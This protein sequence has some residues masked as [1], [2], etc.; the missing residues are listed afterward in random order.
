[1][2]LYLFLGAPGQ[3]MAFIGAGQNM[4]FF[5]FWGSAGQN[6]AFFVLVKTWPF[7][8]LVKTWP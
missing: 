6:M 7:F 2:V 4:A 8:V 3:N 5:C 1:M